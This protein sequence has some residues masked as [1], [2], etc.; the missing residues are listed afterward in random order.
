MSAAVVFYLVGVC[1]VS[2]IAPNTY[3]GSDC[4]YGVSATKM[5]SAKECLAAAKEGNNKHYNN[6]E[7]YCTR[8]P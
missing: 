7:W 8:E 5:G 4:P 3:D 1:T 6:M 2:P